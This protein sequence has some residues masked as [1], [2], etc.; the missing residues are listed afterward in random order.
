M[1]S[2]HL[3]SGC[4]AEDS[5]RYSTEPQKSL[6]RNHVVGLRDRCSCRQLP[7]LPDCHLTQETKR[8]R[9]WLAVDLARRVLACT[10]W[11]IDYC[12]CRRSAITVGR[13]PRIVILPVCRTRRRDRPIPAGCRILHIGWIDKNDLSCIACIAGI[14][15][16]CRSGWTREVRK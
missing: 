12:N 7:V 2:P 4:S 11:L 15:D 6:P 16:P 10:D 8:L 14:R 9:R 5:G 1:S 13:S 3:A